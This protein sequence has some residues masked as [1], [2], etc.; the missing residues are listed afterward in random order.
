MGDITELLAAA[1]QGD[2][3]AVGGLFALLYP[4]LRR[5]ASARLHRGGH[6]L[7]LQTTE[8]VHETFMRLAK[9]NRRTVDDRAHFFAYA[10]RAMRSVIVDLVREQRAANDGDGVQ[11]VTLDTGIGD[12]AAAAGADEVLRVHDAL[13][14]L[15]EVGERMVRVVEMRYFVGLDMDEIARAL[16]VGKRTVERDWEK[17]RS[18]LFASLKG[19]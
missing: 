14:M 18:F 15:E 5:L 17:A 16:G 19:D 8:L 7:P 1:R 3:D 2:A 13:Q 11:W 12:R 6:A 9:L 4:D 10:A